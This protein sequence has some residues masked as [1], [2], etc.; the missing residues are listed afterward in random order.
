MDIMLGQKRRNVVSDWAG[1]LLWVCS[2]VLDAGQQ[3]RPLGGVLFA[4][5]VKC[6]LVAAPNQ[7]RLKCQ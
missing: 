4:E 3:V 2:V 7:G 6:N 1:F 5:V